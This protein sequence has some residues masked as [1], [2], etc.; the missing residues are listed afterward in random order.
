M[1]MN[2]EA[3][4]LC[5][6]TYYIPQFLYLTFTI[7]LDKM[8]YDV[9]ITASTLVSIGGIEIF[10][11]DYCSKKYFWYS[12]LWIHQ[13]LKRFENWVSSHTDWN[14]RYLKYSSRH[15]WISSSI[16]HITSAIAHIS[17]VKYQAFLNNSTKQWKFWN[18]EWYT[19]NI[20]L[21]NTHN[22]LSGE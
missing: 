16:N 13:S 14:L 4:L 20:Y 5:S 3:F 10:K 17:N 1:I 21:E 9:K 19:S 15:R 2:L 8:D 11:T 7:H 12:M 6:L 18:N 22:S